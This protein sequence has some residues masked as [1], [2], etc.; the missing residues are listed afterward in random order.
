MIKNPPFRLKI[1][2]ALTDLIRTV[3]P[4]N[5]HH[6]DLSIDGAVVRGRQT[7]GDDEPEYMVSLLEPP[8]AIEALRN[9][10][11]D[12]TANATEW[13]ILVQGWAK[14]DRDAEDCDL[15]YVLAADVRSVLASE[16]T[17][18]A[19]SRPGAPDLLGMGRHLTSI[20]IGSPVVRPTEEVSG[21]GVFYLIL[22]L[23]IVE[24]MATPFR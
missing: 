14:D 17:R 24:D 5:G 11:V 18:K 19:P 20:R 10:A 2:M 7:I 13:D 4:A 22:T 16:L 23:K 12:N 15:A 6:F 9:K 3:T 8:A 21:Y 1:I